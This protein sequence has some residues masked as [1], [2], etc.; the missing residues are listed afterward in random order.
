MHAEL[1]LTPCYNYF[2]NNIPH[3][4]YHISSFTTRVVH[5]LYI[6][7][8]YTSDLMQPLYYYFNCKEMRVSPER[9]R[10]YF[11]VVINPF[12]YSSW[13]STSHKEA[14]TIGKF[15]LQEIPYLA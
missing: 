11:A 12:E 1:I 5:D 3:V 8:V 10:I 6:E 2:K 7:G 14:D 15:K 9:F 4:P 13:K